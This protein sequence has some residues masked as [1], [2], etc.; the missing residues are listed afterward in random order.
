MSLEEQMNRLL[1]R[2]GISLRAVWLPSDNHEEHAR[3][4]AQEGL[5][6]VYDKCESEAWASLIHEVIEWRLRPVLRV[7]RDTINHLITLI[8]EIA[9]SRKEEALSNIVTDFSVW[10][11][12]GAERL[13]STS[14]KGKR[15]KSS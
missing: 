2:L 13:G 14:N 4:I 8:E 9:Y 7:Y 12:L 5:I 10:R 6:M 15:S 3:I 1:E 11:I